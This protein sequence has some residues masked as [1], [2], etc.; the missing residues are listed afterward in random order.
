MKILEIVKRIEGAS[1]LT[2]L[3]PEDPSII[4]KNVNEQEITRKSLDRPK[5]INEQEI[6]N[7]ASPHFLFDCRAVHLKSSKPCKSKSHFLTSYI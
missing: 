6:K 3:S 5:N 4:L 2:S 1:P 7:E